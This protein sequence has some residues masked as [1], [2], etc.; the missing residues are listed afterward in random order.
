MGSIESV[1]VGVSK[2][3]AAKTGRSGIDKYAVDG[4]VLVSVPPPDGPGLAGDTIVDVPGH[5]GPD[6]AVYAYAREDLQDWAA[7][8][9]RDLR[10]GLFGENL[11]TVGMDVTGAVVGETW[12][13]GE[14]VVLQVTYPRT[15]CVTFTDQMQRP[16]WVKEFTA[17][18]VPGTYLRV[19]R[20]GEVRAGDAVTVLDRPDSPITVGLVFRALHLD[21][22]LLPLLA[23]APDLP[24]KLRAKVDRRVPA[25]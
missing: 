3:Y 20:A 9:G 15:P 5:G 6:Q 17:R 23:A 14:Q 18:A 1:N 12:Q 7:V 4:P 13:V 22:T 25:G 21:P 11:T 2:P 24:P 16:G 8:L 10:G 19:L